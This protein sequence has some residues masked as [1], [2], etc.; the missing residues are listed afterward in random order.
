[1]KLAFHIQE[2]PQGNTSPQSI[3]RLAIPKLDPTLLLAPILKHPMR[4]YELQSNGV[5]R[6]T[7][8]H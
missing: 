2:S 7:E 4:R 1:L 5:G 6:P 8:E 3:H